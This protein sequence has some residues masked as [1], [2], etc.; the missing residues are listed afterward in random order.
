VAAVPAVAAPTTPPATPPAS[1][2]AKAS[3]DEFLA[4]MKAI[5]SGQKMYDPVSKTLTDRHGITPPPE[6]REDPPAP[7]S[8]QPPP[9]IPPAGAGHDIFQR[10]AQS[11]EY[12]GAYDLGSV[13]LDNRFA[14][15][16]EAADKRRPKRAADAGPA[17]IQPP[18]VPTVSPPPPPPES[19]LDQFNADLHDMLARPSVPEP[20]PSLDRYFPDSVPAAPIAAPVPMLAHESTD[21]AEPLYASGEHV[22][23][24]EGLYPHALVI[25][26]KPGL[27]F[28][29]GEIIAMADLF[30]T[31]DE[32]MAAP[33]GE[34]SKIKGLL[35]AD[36]AHYAP[37]G[38]SNPAPGSSEWEWV[39][40]H[41]KPGKTYL[42][43]AEDNYEHFAPLILFPTARA[44]K[45]ADRQRHHKKAWEDHHVRALGE[46]AKLKPGLDPA[47]KYNTWPLIINAFGDHFLTDAFSSG[48]LVNRAEIMDLFA[49]NFYSG[50][51]LTKAGESFIGTVAKLAFK[52]RVAEKFSE[53]E[54]F[55][56]FDRW[57]NV[58]NWNPNIDTVGAFT[59]LL[60]Q[61]ANQAPEKMQIL[62][63]K[64]LHDKLNKEGI[65]VTNGLGAVPWVLKGDGHLIETDATTLKVMQAAVK[66]SVAN[67][68]DPAA[69]QPGFDPKPFLARVWAYVPQLT[70]Q[71]LSYLRAQV[72]NFINPNSVWLAGAAAE[73]IHDEVDTLIKELLDRKKLKPA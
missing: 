1:P 71:S 22:R 8:S 36:V 26:Q 14:Q 53:L 4:D 9:E 57:W 7:P 19:K 29:Y 33:V 21:Y 25:G 44:I 41:R 5:M 52:G 27:A 54:T 6:A 51:K 55:D 73:L 20:P 70:Q 72:P 31:V 61:V 28:S 35:N 48:H 23:A 59:A 68:V 47:L 63:I 69:R 37:G 43:L 46:V 42:G 62:A 45:F 65:E 15:F 18:P 67:I 30:E 50:S 11:M 13:E 49:T 38:R 39:T 58:F 10:I 16:D 40:S 17:G 12:A 56:P 2:S 34:L 32:M 66:Q 3:E 24:G 64:A 60:I